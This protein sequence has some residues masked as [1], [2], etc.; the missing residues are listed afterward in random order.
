MTISR[1]TEFLVEYKEETN[2]SFGSDEDTEDFVT[3]DENCLAFKYSDIG[4]KIGLSW[5]LK[6]ISNN[7]FSAVF[8][9]LL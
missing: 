3:C 1:G 9:R 7:P 5:R 4:I 6:K 2:L 8:N